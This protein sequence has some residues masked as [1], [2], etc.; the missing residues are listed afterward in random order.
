MAE[1][2]RQELRAYKPG[3]VEGALDSSVGEL[4]RRLQQAGGRSEIEAGRRT[5]DFMRRLEELTGLRA[6]EQGVRN[7]ARGGGSPSDY[8]NAG[9]AA[10]PLAVAARPLAGV[11]RR[12]ALAVD[13]AVLGQRTRNRVVPEPNPQAKTSMLEGRALND[14]EQVKYGFRRMS[15]AELDDA[16]KSGRFR[17]P[18]EGTKFNEA[19]SK[20]KWWSAADD[21]GIFGRPWKSNAPYA[22]RLPASN[23]PRGRAAPAK[24]AEVYDEAAKKWMPFKEYTKK[25]AIGGIVVDDGNPAKQRKLI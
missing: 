8:V 9:L 6:G 5:G 1:K 24:Y 25:Y 12:G 17:V 15:L 22:V 23:I 11:A 10:L 18:K 7:I 2:K 4:M 21:E 19:G 3:V 13:E 16:A 14:P 20:D